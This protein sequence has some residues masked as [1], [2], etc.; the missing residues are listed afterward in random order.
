MGNSFPYTK[1]N[2]ENEHLLDGLPEDV[3]SLLKKNQK[4]LPFKEGATIFNEGDV[5]EGIFRVKRGI[6]KKIA[7]THFRLDHLFYLCKAGEYFGHHALLSNER[8]NDTAMALTAC[9]LVF[10]PKDDF[11]KA[12]DVSHVLTGRLL[13][14]LGHEFN[15]FTTYSK[16][17][18]K[19]TVRERVAVF[20]LVLNEKFKTEIN[21]PVRITLS[22]DDLASMVGTTKES[23]V[24]TLRDLKEERLIE[25]EGRSI[26]IKDL[27][28]LFRIT[29]LK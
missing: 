3:T 17:L 7:Q 4:K 28:G 16:V 15:V 5:P 23:V 1:F 18:S 29:N 12:L 22:R 20:I 9:E 6:V 25:S 8:Y 24:R 19:H 11:L 2:F 13:K 10:I 26:H 21:E 14:S 27:E